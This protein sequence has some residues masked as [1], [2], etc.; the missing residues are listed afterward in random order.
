M[1]YEIHVKDPSRKRGARIVKVK[2]DTHFMNDTQFM[3]METNTFGEQTTVCTFWRR[4]IQ[5]YVIR[6]EDS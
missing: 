3:L 5:G 2:A 1:I 4:E 6:M